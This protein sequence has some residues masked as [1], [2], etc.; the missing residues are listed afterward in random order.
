MAAAILSLLATFER[1]TFLLALVKSLLYKGSKM[2][3]LGVKNVLQS[4][5][6]QDVHCV[7]VV[8]IAKLGMPTAF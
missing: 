2:C 1:S 3:F 7:E 4:S 5:W 6:N 8:G